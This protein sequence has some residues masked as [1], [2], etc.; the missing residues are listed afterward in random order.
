[1]ALATIT[2]TLELP[3]GVLAATVRKITVRLRL[4][5]DADT[6]GIGRAEATPASVG[7][8]RFAAVDS[9]GTYTFTSVRPN[10]GSSDDVIT[11]PAGTVYELV[12]RFPDRGAVTRYVSVPD[13]AGPHQVGDIITVAPDPLPT[14]QDLLDLIDAAG[15]DL[16]DLPAG[17]TAD[18][19]VGLD[20]GALVELTPAQVMASHTGDTSDAHDASAISYAGGSGMSATDVEAAIDELAT[21]KASLSGAAFTGDVSVTEASSTTITASVSGS[22]A[23]LT[24][25]AADGAGFAAYASDADT[26]PTV[27]VAHSELFG[28]GFISLGPGGSTAVDTT[29]FRTAAGVI[30]HNGGGLTGLGKGLTLTEQSAPSSPAANDITLYAADNGSGTTVLRTKDSAG[31]VT[32]LGSGAGLTAED[33][34]DTIGTALVEGE[35]IDITVNDGAD[36][37]SIAAEDASDANK[38]VVELATTA[39][40]QTGT[41]ATRAVTP[42]G[43]AATFQR[44][45]T[46]LSAIAGLTSAADKG[47]QFTGAGT[48]ATFDLTAAGKALLDDADAAAQRTTLGVLHLPSTGT[49]IYIAP[50]GARV[51]STSLGGAAGVL[52]AVPMWV[53]A[54]TY[55]RIGIYYYNTG[56]A[57]LRL[58][59]W[60]LD[61]DGQPGTVALD[62]GTVTCTAGDGAVRKEVT[63]SQAFTAGWYWLAMQVDAYTSTPTM[64][65]LSGAAGMQ[66]LPGARSGADTNNNQGLTRTGVTT[67]SLGTWGSSGSGASVAASVPM[68]YLRT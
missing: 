61:A 32:T 16:T 47:I 15:L 27:A 66:L 24:A 8:A 2:E 63:I 39:E 64:M 67:G 60:N 43:A 65:A 53:P 40:T 12:V 21:E 36:T 62:A 35:A 25:S 14:G 46:E 59:V 55:T 45:D 50:A 23:V 26:Q 5:V 6:E 10:S 52:Y 3:G 1:M 56:T 51:G 13:T 9:T 7:G 68:I 44:L 57:T 19:V 29:I 42:A 33:V 58:G 31:T 54:N 49:N 34:R 38:G 37:I 28:V 18:G 48:A 41:D 22:K 20:G 4:V 30:S 11:S 17:V